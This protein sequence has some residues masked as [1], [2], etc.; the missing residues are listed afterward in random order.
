MGYNPT[1]VGRDHSSSIAHPLSTRVK[2]GTP[3]T[4]AKE[5]GSA[6]AE[7]AAPARAKVA[8]G[9]PLRGIRPS[10]EPI[11]PGGLHRMGVVVL[12]PS[13]APED[14]SEGA[15]ARKPQPARWPGA[16]ASGRASTEEQRSDNQRRP[17]RLPC[18]PHAGP[19]PRG[20]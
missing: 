9:P 4:P 13:S 2:T 1:D 17:R 12:L 11:R 5:D 14:R 7:T 19:G 3:P 16:Q 6:Q 18:R 20:P 15:G 8:P 10:P